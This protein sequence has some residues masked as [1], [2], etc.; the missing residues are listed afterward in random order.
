MKYITA[1]LALTAIL[2]LAMLAQYA[3]HDILPPVQPLDG[4]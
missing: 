1:T 3:V 4:K 2:S